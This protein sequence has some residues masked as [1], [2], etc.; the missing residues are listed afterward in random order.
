LAKALAVGGGLV[1]STEVVGEGRC[2]IKMN[3]EVTSSM[4]SYLWFA[5]NDAGLL[6]SELDVPVV[7]IPPEPMGSEVTFRLNVKV[8][9]GEE[10]NGS[11]TQAQL[12]AVRTMWPHLPQTLSFGSCHALLCYRDYAGALLDY[13]FGDEPPSTIHIWQKIVATMVSYHENVATDIRAWSERRYRNDLGPPKIK[14]TKYFQQILDACAELD[15]AWR[16]LSV[17]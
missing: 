3:G 8:P 5:I 14:S 1:F 10:L 6:D 9:D 17:K 16:M 2:E 13:A 12:A 7:M 15:Q 11:A 4:K